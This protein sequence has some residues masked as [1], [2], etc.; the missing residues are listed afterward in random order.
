MAPYMRKFML[1]AHITFSVGWLG[2]VVAYLSLAITGIDSQDTRMIK[3]VYPVLELVGW[4]VIVPAALAAL[5]TGLIQ[6]LFSQWGLFRFYWVL[7]KFI[8]T[9]GAS[10]ILV[11]H[12]P[13]VRRMAKMVAGGKLAG[14]DF[15]MLRVQLLVH[16]ADGLLILIIT[17][18]LSV[19]K[20]WG[21]IM[22]SRGLYLLLGFTG[23]LFL[24]IILHLIG[25]GMSSHH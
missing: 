13:V 17:T 14:P 7:V 23:V 6:S 12:M 9:F 24:F 20:P 25:G 15:N 8:L 18:V 4:S 5:I 19:Y 21:K 10:I 3:V 16:A 2:A 1:I 11:N 22:K